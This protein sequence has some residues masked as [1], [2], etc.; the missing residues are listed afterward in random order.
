MK[1]LLVNPIIPHRNMIVDYS[2]DNG[3]AFDTREMNGP[4]FPLNDLAGILTDEQVRILDLRVLRMA[5]PHL[6][7]E[8]QLFD[9][10][11]GFDPDIVGVTCMTAQAGSALKILRLVKEYDP[12]TLTIVGGIHPTSCPQDFCKPSVDIVVLGL[13]K[14]T[15]RKIVDEFKRKKGSADFSRI[16]GLAMNHKGT[17]HFTRQ[18]SEMS[19]KEIIRDHYCYDIFP[20]R[21]LT[22]KYDYRIR[23]KNMRIHYINT[24]IGCTNKCNFCY[25]WKFY[26][27]YYISRDVSSIVNELKTM[28]AYPVIRFCEAH[29][30]GDIRSSFELFK[31]ILKEDITH[32]YV[33]DVRADAVVRH[34]DVMRTAV[35]AGMKVAIIGLEATTDEELARY[36]KNSTIKTTQEAIRILND[37]GVWISGNYIV[38]CDYD[39]TDFENMARF[40]DDHPIFFSGFTILTPFP[41]T[42]QYELLKDQIVI[43][44]PDYYNLTNAVLKTKLSEDTFYRKVNELYQV[45]MKSRDKYFSMY[46]ERDN[47]NRE[48]RHA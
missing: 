42:E 19:R 31:Q 43:K 9:E 32:E 6:D 17:L 37:A 11:S 4:P 39:E 12:K 23:H 34:P 22:E 14:R 3:T 36:G 21:A 25:L 2:D 41:G 7:I 24:S 45:G 28:E 46:G 29:S 5:D 30:F 13:G 47:H 16:P 33:V 27:G 35:Q 15:L 48:V 44:D 8:Q 38:R 18:L 1:I 20:N 40:V 10:L 26:N